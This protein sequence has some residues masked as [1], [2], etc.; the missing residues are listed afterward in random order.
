MMNA[1][2]LCPRINNFVAAHKPVRKR[3]GYAFVGEA[4][5]FHENNKGEPFI[6]PTGQELNDHYLLLAGLTRSECYITNAVKC[7]P[8]SPDHKMDITDRHDRELIDSCCHTHL[9]NE[10]VDFEL[11]VPM[12]A[13]A[14]YAIDPDINLELHHGSPFM[15]RL[16]IMAFPMYHPAGGIHE[17]KKMLQIRTDWIRFGLWLKNRLEVPVDPHPIPDYKEADEYDIKHID[18]TI[19]MANDTERSRQYGAYCLTY[20][21]YPGTGRLIMASSSRLLGM[22]QEKLNV[23][24][25]TLLWHNWIYDRHNTD[26]MYLNYY[27]SGKIRDT[28]IRAFH[29]GNLPQ[30]LK[31]LAYR[32]LGMI[33]EDFDDLVVPYSTPHVIEYYRAAFR[34]EWP[35]PEPQ[36]VKDEDGNPKL[37]KPQGFN[38]KLKRFFT[39]WNKNPNKDIF[40]MWEKN[41]EEIQSMVE[42]VC[43]LWPGKDIAHVPFD[44]MLYYACRDADA[45]LRLSPILDEMKHRVRKGPQE[46]WRQGVYVKA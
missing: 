22:F 9:Y 40:K 3:N 16:G 26:E 35:K 6:G 1:C 25:S 29:L 43:G 5:G 36:W 20:S 39:D 21:Q 37:Y 46:T 32:E 14:C 30:K 31:V 4:P 17:P 12:G 45:G 33:M 8:I 34:Y 7:L 13:I 2:T 44:R 24:E 18:P 41:W 28:M 38:T 42:E 23:W 15:T 11:I 19:P 10:L 27:V